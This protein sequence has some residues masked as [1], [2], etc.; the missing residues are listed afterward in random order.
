MTDNTENTPATSTAPTKEAKAI[1]SARKVYR[2]AGTHLVMLKGKRFRPADAKATAFEE[3][4]QLLVQLPAGL[5]VA[6]AQH[7][8][9]SNLQTPDIQEKWV[10]FSDEERASLKRPRS[11]NKKIAASKIVADITP[12]SE[13]TS[14]SE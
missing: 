5:S 9:V 13:E 7:V 12:G 8:A 2:E 11:P 1:A 14:V 6:D 4:S 3:Q 10:L